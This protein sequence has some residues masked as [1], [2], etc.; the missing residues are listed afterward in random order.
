[1]EGGDPSASGINDLDNDLGR[2]REVSEGAK[3]YEALRADTNP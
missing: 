1:M 2:R 3:L